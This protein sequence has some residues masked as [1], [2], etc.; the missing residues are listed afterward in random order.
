MSRPTL[1]V[2]DVTG[3][4]AKLSSRSTDTGPAEGNAAS[5]ERSFS[6]ALPPSVVTSTSATH[7]LISR[8]S[9]TH[10]ATATALSASL[11]PKPNGLKLGKK[12]CC[13]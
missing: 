11:W 4:T 10:V 12:N 13:P 9:I 1:E 6:V 5:C 3:A 7:A 2:A 8:R